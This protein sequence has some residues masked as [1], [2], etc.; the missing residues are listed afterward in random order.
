MGSC[1]THSLDFY[2]CLGTDGTDLGWENQ[3]PRIPLPESHERRSE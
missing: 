2:S 1:V 3:D